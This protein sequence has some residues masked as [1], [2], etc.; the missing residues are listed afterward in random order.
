MRI[1]TPCE[2]FAK[3]LFL[4]RRSEHFIYSTKQVK[5]GS[6]QRLHRINYAI[7]LF[8]IIYANKRLVFSITADCNSNY[9]HNIF[10]FFESCFIFQTA[11]VTTQIIFYFFCYIIVAS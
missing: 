10:E 6:V 3:I 2:V 11:N 8:Y 4:F 5:S 7:N 9:F 1:M